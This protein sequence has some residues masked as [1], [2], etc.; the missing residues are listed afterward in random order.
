MDAMSTTKKTPNEFVVFTV[1][2]V[3]S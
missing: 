3:S 1:F 2:I